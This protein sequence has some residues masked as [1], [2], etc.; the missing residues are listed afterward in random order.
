MTVRITSPSTSS[1][2]ASGVRSSSAWARAIATECADGRVR[3]QASAP[4]A[5]PSAALLT[6]LF[7][8]TMTSKR[9]EFQS[10]RILGLRALALILPL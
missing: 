8:V 3:C 9:L 5:L 6:M 1:C 7:E 2:A 4:E 10:G